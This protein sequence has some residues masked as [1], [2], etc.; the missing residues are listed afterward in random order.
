[1]HTVMGRR[2]DGYEMHLLSTRQAGG[3][4]IVD[5]DSARRPG[6]ATS[7]RP[8][9]G[10][11]WAERAE[12]PGPY[13]RVVA[14]ARGRQESHDRPVRFRLTVRIVVTAFI[15]LAVAAPVT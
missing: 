15:S 2:A 5:S 4:G 7:Y 11:P 6:S 3:G 13:S 14:S 9:T 12:W 8:I 10:N 1:M